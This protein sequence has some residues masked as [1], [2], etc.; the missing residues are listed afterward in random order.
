MDNSAILLQRPNLGQ[1]A[2]SYLRLYLTGSPRICQF[3][4]VQARHLI[5]L[6][7]VTA[8]SVLACTVETGSRRE[9]PNIVLIL[10]DDLGYETL[11]AYGGRSYSTPMLDRLARQGTRFDH[12]YSQPLCTNTRVQLMTGRYQH[13]YWQGFGILPKGERTFGHLM[14]EAGY[15]TLISGKWQL[16]SY[17]PVDYPGA[18]KRR[19]TGMRGADSGFDE[20]LLWHAWH[21]EDKGS[22]YADPTYDLNGKLVRERTGAYGPDLFGDY[23]NDFVERNR[24]VPFFVYY[25]MALPHD[26]FV[27]TPDSPQW[28]DESRRHESDPAYFADMVAYMDK[29]VGRIVA[30]LDRLGLR[31]RTLV[32]FYA[33]NG[34]HRMISSQLGNRTIQGGKGKTTDAGTRVPMIASWPGTVPAG[35]ASQDLIDSVDI[36]PTLAELAGIRLTDQPVIDGVSFADRLSGR[37]GDPRD[38]IFMHFEPRPGWDKDKYTQL[39]FVRDRQYKLY[40]NGEL[41]AV[42]SDVLEANPIRTSRR[43]EEQRRIT[44]KFRTIMERLEGREQ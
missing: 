8:A 21:T 27:P 4:H 17:D 13:R 12:A 31:Q 5:L 18:A 41:Y 29:L 33:D 20:Y 42:E 24:D 44:E 37:D 30:N 32:L 19:G 40:G 39:T 1:W 26:P 3:F 25:P 6:G 22:R 9:R 28:K 36:F 2:S 11:G 38:W 7:M 16:H 43:T 14:Q 10:A 35:V 23:I 34:T 15:R